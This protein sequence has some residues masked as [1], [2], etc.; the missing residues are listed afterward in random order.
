MEFDIEKI[1]NDIDFDYNFI[2]YQKN[3]IVLTKKETT[4]L[5]NLGINYESYNT[6]SSII[7]ALEEYTDDP[8][9]EE[10]LEN[11]SDRNY[12]LNVNK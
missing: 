10:V 11:I 5:N 9:V 1:V 6:M 7:N 4:L 8:Y 12:Y 3:D 2:A